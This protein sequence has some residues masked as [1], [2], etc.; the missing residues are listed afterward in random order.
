MGFGS[1]SIWKIEKIPEMVDQI[2][3]PKFLRIYMKEK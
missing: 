3:T 1:R 2:F